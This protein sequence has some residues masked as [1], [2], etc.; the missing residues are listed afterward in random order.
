MFLIQFMMLLIV[1][2]MSYPSDRM[3]SIH[4]SLEESL[5]LDGAP[6]VGSEEEIVSW[7][8]GFAQSARQ[9]APGSAFVA[10]FWSSTLTCARSCTGTSL[11]SGAS[12]WM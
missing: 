10:E 7:L 8:Q 6:R 11:P 4:R 1:L 3:R 12:L 2:Y 5:G 9:F